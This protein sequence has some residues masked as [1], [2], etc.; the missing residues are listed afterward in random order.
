MAD[1]PGRGR[2]LLAATKLAPGAATSK[3]SGLLKSWK[4]LGGGGHEVLLLF[5]EW[6]RRGSRSEVFDSVG[7]WMQDMTNAGLEDAC[8]VPNRRLISVPSQCVL[9]ERAW[10]AA[11]KVTSQADTTGQRAQV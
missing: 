5:V 10:A 8:Q 2:G 6:S 4:Y 11:Q 7:C 1:V 3:G 9:Y